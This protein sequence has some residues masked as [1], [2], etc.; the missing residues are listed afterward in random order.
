[1]PDFTRLGTEIGKL[2]QRKNEQYGDSFAQAH[3]IL[4]VLYPEGVQ[5]EQYLDMLAVIRIIDK[6]FRV[7]HGS[8]GDESPFFDIAGYG[9]LGAVAHAERSDEE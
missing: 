5:P 8:Q 6:L 4:E 3:Q 1:M 9:I 7:A 2:V